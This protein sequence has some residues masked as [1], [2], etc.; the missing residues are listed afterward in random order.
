MKYQNEKEQD[1]TFGQVA[2][3]VTGEKGEITVVVKDANA[4][5]RLCQ[6]FDLVG[7]DV[8]VRMMRG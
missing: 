6:A 7:G 3:G 1:F 8:Y 4:W 5:T 2:E